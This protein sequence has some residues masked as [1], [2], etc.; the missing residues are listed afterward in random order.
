MPLLAVEQVEELAA[1]GVDVRIVRIFNTYGPT[2]RPHDG[3]VVSNFIRQALAGEPLTVYGDGSQTRSFCYVD[4]LIEGMMRMMDQDSDVG[5]VNL[6]N[7]VENTMIELAEKVRAATGSKSRQL[8][9]R[10]G[11][12]SSGGR[13]ARPG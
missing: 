9:V 2:M 7:P 1:R 13:S 3:R 8:R 11:M 5:P 12:H 6:G 4:D 10:P